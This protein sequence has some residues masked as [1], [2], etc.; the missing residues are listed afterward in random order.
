[1][2]SHN[3]GDRRDPKDIPT[4]SYPQNEG[5]LQVF[6]SAS[7]TFLAPSDPSGIGG[8]RW[9]HICACP[10]WRNEYPCNDCVFINTDSDAQGMR[11]L[12]VA[13][14]ICFFSF[15]HDWEGYPCAFIQWFDKIS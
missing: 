10:L 8:M 5:K 3:R 4:G 15:I 2:F 11:G 14:I 13:R 7:A 9:E 6:N 1:M 12:E